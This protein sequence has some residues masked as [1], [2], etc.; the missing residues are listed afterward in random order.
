ML[1]NRPLLTEL[2]ATLSVRIKKPGVSESV[3]KT[4]QG[5]RERQRTTEKD[6]DTE[7]GGGQ[8]EREKERER[9]RPQLNQQTVF[10]K[11]CNGEIK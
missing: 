2:S 6:R 1:D 10:Y 8:R 4:R 3:L 9:E 7:N 5:R 11:Q